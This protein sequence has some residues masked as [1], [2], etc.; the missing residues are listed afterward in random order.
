MYSSQ[1]NV[2]WGKIALEVDAKTRSWLHLESL[3]SSGMKKRLLTNSLVGK[4]K[5]TNVSLAC[6]CR[7]SSI[8]LLLL[9]LP[10]TYRHHNI[11]N[12]N[13]VS[14]Q[15][16]GVQNLKI[17]HN[18]SC[19]GVFNN[20]SQ[21]RQTRGPEAVCLVQELNAG[22]LCGCSVWRKS[23]LLPGRAAHQTNLQTQTQ[24]S[25]FWLSVRLFFF[26]PSWLPLRYQEVNCQRTLKKKAFTANA[27]TLVNCP[28]SSQRGYG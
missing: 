16:D 10:T 6:L 22:H 19:K 17:W 25:A 28:C 18:W 15:K 9:Q 20:E 1:E 8:W 21:V 7:T 27:H 12:F 24:L 4:H 3:Q 13:I 5:H 2:A 11:S 23:Y 26:P 14:S